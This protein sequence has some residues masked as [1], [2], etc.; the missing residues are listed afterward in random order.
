M[1]ICYSSPKS[2]TI[3]LSSLSKG[4]N[5]HSYTKHS[6]IKKIQ[7][8]RS[9]YRTLIR[10]T[11]E[12]TKLTLDTFHRSCIRNNYNGLVN[13]NSLLFLTR[14][15]I[16]NNKSINTPSIYNDYQCSQNTKTH[17]K[18]NF[19]P[20]FISRRLNRKNQIKKANNDNEYETLLTY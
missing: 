2:L 5:T 16:N 10:N 13:S 7:A 8:F 18:I 1:K 6:F 14:S 12:K 11:Q 4:L 17:R 3:S 15:A 9:N 19:T 20:L